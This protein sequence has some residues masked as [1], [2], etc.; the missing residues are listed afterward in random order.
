MA[1]TF[2]AD[3]RKFVE[4]AG[5]RADVAVKA[6]VVGIHA[7]VD[8][9][10]P[11]DTGRFRG[12]W[13]LGIGSAPGGTLERLDKTG[14]ETSVSIAAAIPGD[15]A[16]NVY[17]IANNL[18]YA[19]RLENGWSQQAPSGMVALTMLEVPQIAEEAVAV[20]KAARP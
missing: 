19:Q 1:G 12:N 4:K 6:I 15:A 10:S 14:G 3:I 2:E 18:P 8:K 13:Q 9:R 16:G 11:V 17:Y 5:E 20:A 7:R